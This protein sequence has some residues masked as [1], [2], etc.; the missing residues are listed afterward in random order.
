MKMRLLFPLIGFALDS[1]L[2]RVL[3]VI[4]LLACNSN[5]ALQPSENRQDCR[6]S[7]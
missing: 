1:M 7:K 6:I 4:A 5:A 3:V 2:A